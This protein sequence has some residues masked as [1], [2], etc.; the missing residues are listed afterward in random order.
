MA[1]RYI[2]QPR[3][4]GD[5]YSLIGPLLPYPLWYLD[6]IQAGHMAHHLGRFA[7]GNVVYL[8]SGGYPVAVERID[9][10]VRTPARTRREKR[11]R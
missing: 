3:P 11:G 10:E 5:G 4:T 1:A 2:V 8:D 6:E 9:P 7:G